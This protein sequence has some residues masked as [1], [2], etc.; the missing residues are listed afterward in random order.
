MALLLQESFRRSWLDAIPLSVLDN[1]LSELANAQGGC[2]RIRNT[3]AQAVRLLS[4]ALCTSLLRWV[5]PEHVGEPGLVDSHLANH[6]RLRL[7]CLDQIG[8]EVE[9]P[10]DNSIHDIQLTSICR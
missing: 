5:A 10:F 8:R 3:H 1:N 4:N 6:R 2:E 9:F 7:S